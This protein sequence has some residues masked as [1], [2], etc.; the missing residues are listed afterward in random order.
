MEGGAEGLE[1]TAPPPDTTYSKD[2]WIADWLDELCPYY[3]HLGVTLYDFWH[4]DYTM[5]GYYVDAHML[6][7]EQRNQEYFVLSNYIGEHFATTLSN[8]FA[9]KGT[10]HQKY[11]QEPVRLTPMSEAEKREK[12]RQ[13]AQ[14]L[15]DNLTRWAE[16]FNRTKTNEEDAV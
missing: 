13:E 5:L 9:K 8:A 6:S 14:A 3:M 2:E 12:E 11:R 4:G 1:P 16:R 15:R 7:I 10:A